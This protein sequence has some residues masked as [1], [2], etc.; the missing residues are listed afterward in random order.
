MCISIMRP[1]SFGRCGGSSGCL[2]GAIDQRCVPPTTTSRCPVPSPAI[3]GNGIIPQRGEVLPC[4]ICCES[5][6]PCPGPVRIALAGAP[7]GAVVADAAA[8]AVRRPAAPARVAL[9][10]DPPGH[11]HLAPHAGGT[12][13][14]PSRHGRGHAHPVLSAQPPMCLCI[15]T[16]WGSTASLGAARACRSSLTS[17]PPQCRPPCGRQARI[18]A[19]AARLTLK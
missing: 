3:L 6:A 14:S 19:W 12:A 11:R 16:A 9:A 13:S 10:G 4:A 8:H 15:D 7:M 1:K 2:L 18:R 17:L 5:L